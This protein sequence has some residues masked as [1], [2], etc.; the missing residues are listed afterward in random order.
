MLID[1]L[2]DKK[3][4]DSWMKN[5]GPWTTA[6]REGQIESRRLITDQAIIEAITEYS[7]RTVLDVGCGEGWLCKRLFSLGIKAMGVD[8]VPELIARAQQSAGGSFK[9]LS[10]E[11]LAAGALPENFD[12]LAC[13]FSLL[14]KESVE[15][16]IGA[17]PQLLRAGGTL[18]I[19][20]LHPVAACGPAPYQDGWRHGSWTGFDATFTDPAPWYFRTIESW[21]RLFKAHGLH[22]DNVREPI[23]AKTGQ[24]A[25]IIFTLMSSA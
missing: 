13:N 8:V 7:P 19:Q 5:A 23:N 10:Y 9:V 18:V 22:L 25:S 17:A 20:T 24:P 21:T 14:G 3:I 12:L 11:A 6:V 4:V 15:G 1:P 16:V 2:S